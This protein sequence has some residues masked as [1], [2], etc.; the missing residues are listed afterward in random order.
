MVLVTAF[1]RAQSYDRILQP[2]QDVRMGRK[3][4]IT[5]WFRAYYSQSHNRTA[6]VY[7][8]GQDA[9]MILGDKYNS[10]TGLT[11]A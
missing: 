8:S 10:S 11:S 1:L 5:K 9:K 6:D 3:F 4:V 2:I 7:A